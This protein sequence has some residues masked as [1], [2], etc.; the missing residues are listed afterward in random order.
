MGS[1]VG[2][3]P[4]GIGLLPSPAVATHLCK[5]PLSAPAQNVFGFLRTPLKLGHVSWSSFHHLEGNRQS[6]R[7]FEALH[8]VEN[9]ESAAG[10][11]VQCEL[12]RGCGVEEVIQGDAVGFGEVHHV[13]VVTNA[14]AIVRWV[15][16]AEDPEFVA[17]ARRDLGN[18][19]KKVIGNAEGVFPNPATWM[20]SDG[21]GQLFEKR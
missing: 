11:D 3:I 13:Q 6:R 8:N 15:V 19:R 1:W 2:A 21:G 20:R 16:L 9:A 12:V 14:G 18:K 17:S 10:T 5:I 4:H 7:A